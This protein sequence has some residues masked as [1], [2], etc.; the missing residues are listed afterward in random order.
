MI[1][2]PIILILP[3]IILLFNYYNK[4]SGLKTYK[5]SAKP[6]VPVSVVVPCR[7]EEHNISS[8]L[9]SLSIQ[10]YPTGLFEIIVVNDNSTDKT[11][12]IATNHE[13]IQKIRV[14][15][16]ESIGKKSAI[17]TGI[18]IS[19]GD[20]IITTD[21]DCQMGENWIRVIASFYKEHN[22]DMIICPVKLETG[23]GFLRSFQELEFLSL[24]GVTAGS[25]LTGKPIMCNGANLAFS[26]EMYLRHSNSIHDEISSGD[27]I[28]LLHS[29]KSEKNS[30]IC[31]IESP[32]AIVTTKASATIGSFLQQ[33]KRWISKGTS[34]TDTDTI[35]AGIST[36]SI[37][38]LQLVYL[39]GGLFNSTLLWALLV[40][41]LIKS[42]PDF[43][44]IRNTSER[45]GKRDIMRWFLPSQII[46]P[47][48][49]MLVILRKK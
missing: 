10:N 22:P 38:I 27:D 1:W 5:K 25:A 21:A 36:F 7:N 28:F 13:G 11:F 3:Y 14:V 46:Y 30:K 20:L 49:V 4:L 18:S 42:I 12:E 17:R 16:N 43:L 34:Y 8:L 32:E 29:L 24:Q 41:F 35:V 47:L 37:V 9:D 23:S 45:Y 39:I 48:Y 44:I 2:L 40:I 15:N 6:A 26:K 31:W 33:R 19:E